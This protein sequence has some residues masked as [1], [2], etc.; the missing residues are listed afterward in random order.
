MTSNDLAK[1][2]T[3]TEST[4][5]RACK[6]RNKNFLK[7]GSTQEIIGIS[8]EY[9]VEILHKKYFYMELTMQNFSSGR[10][11]RSDTIQDLKEF[12]SRSLTTHAEKGQQLV[13]MVPTTKKAFDLV[14]DGIV[15]L[16]TEN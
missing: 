12:N 16:S 5:R 10:T 6:K 3:T 7:A 1:P 14:G 9:S 8:Y 4:V 15:E 13:S 2:D 11:V